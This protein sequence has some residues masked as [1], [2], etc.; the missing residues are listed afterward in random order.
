MLL[1]RVLEIK[2]RKNTSSAISA[3]MK[4]LLQQL[5]I[6]LLKMVKKKSLRIKFKLEIY[7]VFAQGDK[8]PADGEIMEGIVML[9]NP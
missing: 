2:A 3:L 7:C 8:I 9:M 5:L 1:G 6:V 4:L